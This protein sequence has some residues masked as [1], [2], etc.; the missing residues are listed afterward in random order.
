MRTIV[1]ILINTL[2]DLI[3]GLNTTTLQSDV[4][5]CSIDTRVSTFRCIDV[6]VDLI[7][8]SLNEWD[9]SK[10]SRLDISGG[11]LTMIDEL[12]SINLSPLK[13]HGLAIR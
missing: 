4:N 6:P 10:V 5:K 13:I 3:A 2:V 9:L 8:E 1:L 7:Q 12:R 11:M